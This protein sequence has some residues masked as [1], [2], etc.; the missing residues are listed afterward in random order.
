M[1]IA[2]IKEVGGEYRLDYYPATGI[3]P[4]PANRAVELLQETGYL[5]RRAEDIWV[6]Q[7]IIQDVMDLIAKAEYVV[8][9]LT[10]KNPNVL[11]EV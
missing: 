4:I 6:N 9:D 11:Y 7:H 10:G 2:D 8:C 5:C 3:D 1:Y